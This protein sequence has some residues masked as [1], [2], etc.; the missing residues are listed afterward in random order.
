[1][2][3]SVAHELT[4]APHCHLVAL[5]DAADMR[6]SAIREG[7]VVVLALV[8]HMRAQILRNC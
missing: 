3:C 4:P 5:H 1:M 6:L 7:D 8:D 2:C